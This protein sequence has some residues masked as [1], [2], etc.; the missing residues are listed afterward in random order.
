MRLAAIPQMKIFENRTVAGRQA[1]Q[2]RHLP[3]VKV[4]PE[5]AAIR[6]IPTGEEYGIVS[7]GIRKSAIMTKIL[8][9]MA[10]VK[11]ITGEARGHKSSMV[12][13]LTR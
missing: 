13:G 5:I 9:F 12:V 1:R 2:G 7:I 8:D 11:E 6:G 3:G 4:T 10:R